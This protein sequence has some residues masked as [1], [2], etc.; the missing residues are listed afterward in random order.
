MAE[1]KNTL[2]F[3]DRLGTAWTRPVDDSEAYR[4]CFGCTLG[5]ARV[6]VLLNNMLGRK[7]WVPAPVGAYD[8]SFHFIFGVDAGIITYL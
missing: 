4:K 8:E 3:E 7:V 2:A 1:K 5:R 6:R